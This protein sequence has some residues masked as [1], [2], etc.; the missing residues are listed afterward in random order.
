ME[1]GKQLEPI[2]GPGYIGLENLGNSCY[3]NAVVQTLFSLKPIYE[4]YWK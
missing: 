3:L 1:E 2:F 4:P